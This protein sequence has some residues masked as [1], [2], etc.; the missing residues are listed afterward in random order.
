MVLVSVLIKI[1]FENSFWLSLNQNTI[2]SRRKSAQGMFAMQSAQ[3]S[4]CHSTAIL[5]STWGR[6]AFLPWGNAILNVGLYVV[7]EWY[8][9]RICTI[10]GIIGFFFFF[11]CHKLP[12]GKHVS[13]FCAWTLDGK[14]IP[15]PAEFRN[16]VCVFWSLFVN[17]VLFIDLYAN[18]WHNRIFFQ[19]M[20][21]GSRYYVFVSIK[22]CEL[23]T[24]K[25]GNVSAFVRSLASKSMFAVPLEQ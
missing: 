7:Q 21:A 6:T 2:F 9:F 19:I 10:I 13:S 14:K 8:G 12:I 24:M 16:R 5:Y 11:T 23:T 20:P 17:H 3:V 25:S 1:P 4:G 22:P 18:E 15:L